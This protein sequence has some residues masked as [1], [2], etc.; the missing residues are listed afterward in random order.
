MLLALKIVL[1][2]IAAVFVLSALLAC[3]FFIYACG[4]QKK[5]PTG[6]GAYESVIDQVNDGWSWFQSRNPELVHIHSFDGYKL[7]ADVVEHPN[8]RGVVIMMHGFHSCGRLDFGS[9]VK[10][11][12]DWGFTLIV[13]DQRANGRSEGPYVTF[14]VREGK[15][16]RDWAAYAESRWG[17]LPVVLDG[18]SL[19]CATVLF[20]AGLDLPRAV[21][22]I[23][24]DCGFTSPRAIMTDVM[25][26]SYHL[27]AFPIMSI[28]R[29]LC[30][31]FAR[32]DINDSTVTGL[33]KTRVPIFFAHGTGDD[34]VP[35]WMT[36]ENYD[37]CASEKHL[38]L[39]EGAGHGLSWF[40]EHDRYQSELR[41]FLDTYVLCG[42][43]E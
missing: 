2:V 20:A 28:A 22:G 6:G 10:T 31:V 37:A 25:R 40:V 13:P 27:P 32:F 15:D 3:G 9:V 7:A 5:I 42:R 4:R 38:L 41:E 35:C 33:K 34:F 29:V 43:T 17:G 8:A 12:Y 24:A 36:R 39:A 23:I 19:G 11:I 30:K 16:A 21:K 26:K 14:G 18:V 1:I